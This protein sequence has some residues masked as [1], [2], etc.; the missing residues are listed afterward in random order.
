MESWIGKVR[1]P[2]LNTTQVD[3]DLYTISDMGYIN[4]DPGSI[5][6]GNTL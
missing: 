2:L 3:I 4:G 1:P 6:H 5:P